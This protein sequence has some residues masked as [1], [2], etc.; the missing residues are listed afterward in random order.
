MR[1]LWRGAFVAVTSLLG[2]VLILR[3]ALDPKVVSDAARSRPDRATLER[4]G[5]LRQNDFP[6]T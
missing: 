2:L 3:V 1:K 6:E 5:S 4:A